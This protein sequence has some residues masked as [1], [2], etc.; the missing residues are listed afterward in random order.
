MGHIF[1]ENLDLNQNF[2]S[3]NALEVKSN[4]ANP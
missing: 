4:E 2:L 3:I 1:V